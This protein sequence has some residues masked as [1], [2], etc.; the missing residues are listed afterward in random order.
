MHYHR[1]YHSLEACRLRRCTHLK[2]VSNVVV[3]V[4]WL[5]GIDSDVEKDP[6]SLK[7]ERMNVV[8]YDDD[9]YPRPPHPESLD[10]SWIGWHPLPS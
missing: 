8:M 10:L 7:D 3:E 9:L 5:Q 6:S 2:I 4:G 1:L